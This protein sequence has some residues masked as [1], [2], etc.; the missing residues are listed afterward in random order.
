MQLTTELSKK[1]ETKSFKELQREIEKYTH[2]V[3][4]FKT[5]L[6]VIDRTRGR[7][8]TRIQQKNDPP[9]GAI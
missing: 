6:S 7:Q 2:Y 4:D 1:Y 8:S 5:P 9:T 3:G